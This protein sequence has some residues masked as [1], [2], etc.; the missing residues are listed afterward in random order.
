MMD[1]IDFPDYFLLFLLFPSRR[2]KAKGQMVKGQRQMVNGRFIYFIW[3]R[4][5]D[6]VVESGEGMERVPGGEGHGGSEG[7]L[8]RGSGIQGG[9]GGV[10]EGG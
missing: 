8:G 5:V 1:E 2:P 9:E 6:D 4:L 7:I 3:V 10:R